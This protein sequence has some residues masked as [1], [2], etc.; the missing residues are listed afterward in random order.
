M[1]QGPA[2]YALRSGGPAPALPQ[3]E[4]QEQQ[5]QQDQQPA[6]AIDV[7]QPIQQQQVEPVPIQQLEE[8]PAPIQQDQFN[9]AHGT[10]KL[11]LFN[12]DGAQDIESYVKRFEQWQ[13]CTNT[14]DEQALAALRWHLA[15]QARSWFEKLQTPP[16]T[17]AELKTALTNKFKREKSVDMAIF[18]LKQMTSETIT[19]FLNRLEKEAFKQDLGQNMIVQIALNGLDKAVGCAIST[20]GPQT[21]DDVRRVASRQQT[22]TTSSVH[23][24]DVDVTAELVAKL[25]LMTAALTDLRTE[26]NVMK[27]NTHPPAQRNHGPVQNQSAPARPSEQGTAPRT[28]CYRCGG[29]SCFSIRSCRAMGKICNKCNKP[30]HFSSVCRSVLNNQ[31][32]NRA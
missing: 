31:S 27:A 20:H 5:D 32:F 26:V 21:L 10:F 24:A 1:L 13:K 28:P 29:R 14:N 2:N 19:E 9:M 25:E 17:I 3:P 30:N 23:S 12:G 15:G 22:R 16:T 7:E 11:E 6:E 8:E 18:S 4:Q